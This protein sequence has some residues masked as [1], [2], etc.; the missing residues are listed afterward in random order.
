M[1]NSLIVATIVTVA[2]LFLDSLAGY[3]SPSGSWTR[4]VVLI[5]P[6]P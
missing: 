3:V 4:G 1:I 2:I 6:R 5:L